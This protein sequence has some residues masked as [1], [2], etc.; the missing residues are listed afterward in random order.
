MGYKV[1]QGVT[2]IPVWLEDGIL[3]SDYGDLEK[4]ISVPVKTIN[5]QKQCNQFV[6]ENVDVFL[7]NEEYIFVLRHDGTGCVATTKGYLVT[8]FV[9]DAWKILSDKPVSYQG[10]MEKY[11]NL[12]PVAVVRISN[13]KYLLSVQEVGFSGIIGDKSCPELFLQD[14]PVLPIFQYDESTGKLYCSM[15][16]SGSKRELE[17]EIFADTCVVLGGWV[18]DN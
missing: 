8:S 2:A 14:G 1:A 16:K 3:Y 6:C 10:S 13:D 11:G 9:V 18:N 12:Y 15:N 4:G 17:C 7:R 5:F